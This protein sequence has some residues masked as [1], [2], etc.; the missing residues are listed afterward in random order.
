MECMVVPTIFKANLA[1]RTSSTS[2]QRRQAGMGSVAT[3]TTSQAPSKARH[4]RK[5]VA[6]Q[7]TVMSSSPSRSRNCTRAR[8][9]N[10][11]RT[12]TS[13]V[14]T[15]LGMFTIDALFPGRITN[16][17]FRTGGKPKAKARK[18]A[19]CVGSGQVKVLKTL[20]PGITTQKYVDCTSCKGRGE[21]YRE[22]D[23]C[24]YCTGTGLT[25]ETKIL[26]AY[27]PRGAQDG[28]KV[29]LDGEADEEYGK[30]PGSVI[31]EVNQKPHEVFE[32][33]HHDLYTTITI[34]LAEAVCGFSR[35]VLQHLD[36]RGIRIT[37]PPGK[38]I[39]PNEIIKIQRE[40]MPIP[41]TDT[42]GDLYLYVDIKFP[43]DGWCL[44]NSEL[45]KIRD[46]LPDLP[47]KDYKIREN[48]IDDVDFTID[49]KENL[50]EYP[51]SEDDDQPQ[52]S[53]GC[54][55]Q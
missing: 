49:K 55:T 36:G 15:V 33:K 27:F 35:V 47:S 24:K 48:Q 43:E 40:G 7:K 17:N 32:R 6:K 29:V 53:E 46:V 30:K 50:P 45:R 26:E 4:Q 44:E 1:Q 37:N 28:H 11:Q 13:Y 14:P 9:S 19:K 31:I 18:C 5:R 12:A 42:A 10:S 54:T 21:L 25:E 38:V 3:D 41:R 34:S 2:L 23:R 20:A 51:E 52:A 16:L 39:R 8:L 22:K